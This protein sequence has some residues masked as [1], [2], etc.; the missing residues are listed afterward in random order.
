MKAPLSRRNFLKLSGGMAA[1]GLLASGLPTF[2]Q[3]G[4][5]IRAHTRSGRQAD[6]QKYWAESFNEENAGE[7]NVVIEDFP[8]LGVFP[9][10]QYAGS[11][12]RDRRSV[13][14]IID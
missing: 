7:I 4:V 3:D 14:D 13:L 11:W 10:D 8:R 1:G 6:A 5:T 12:R 9:E 2:A